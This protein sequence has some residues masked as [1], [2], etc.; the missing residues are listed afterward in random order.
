MSQKQLSSEKP[1]VIQIGPIRWLQENLFSSWV[2]AFLTVAALF[3]LYL[4]LS[5]LLGWA[6]SEARWEVIPTSI[7]LLLVGT[8]PE[9]QLWRVWATLYMVSFFLGIS[10]GLHRNLIR[11]IGLT[12]AISSVALAL[13]P[14]P[15]STRLWL[16]AVAGFAVLGYG[17]GILL[18]GKK[19]G[20]RLETILWIVSFPMTII[21]LRGIGLSFNLSGSEIA[22]LPVVEQW[23]LWG[24]TLN[25]LGAAVGIALSLPI[26][27]LLALGRRSELP[28]VRL[29]CT[30]YIEIIR[31]MPL[32]AL[33]FIASNLLPL[34]IP[35]T[36]RPDIVIR[37]MITITAFSAAYMAENV[38]GGLQS[39]PHGQSEAAYAIGLNGFLTTRLIVLPQALR[40]VIPAI[41]GQFISLFK[42]TTLFSFLAVLE[43]VG[44]ARAVLGNQEWRDTIFE[45]LIFAAVVFWV[46]C[47]GLSYVS[48][49]I[50]KELGVGER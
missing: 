18:M 43:I 2:N 14:I 35:G 36:F 44:M 40:A 27:I 21:I 15:L 24:F 20:T 22:I 42:D 49:R 45:L 29:I 39:I 17:L 13:L 50:E 37:A 4:F 8:Y 38:R 16:L 7:K 1:P 6:F 26:G 25:I 23:N 30:L 11:Q 48:R 12:V 10:G 47:Y 28:A 34:V 41:V 46:F 31:G 32:V 33:L 5:N 3:I 9:E 19:I